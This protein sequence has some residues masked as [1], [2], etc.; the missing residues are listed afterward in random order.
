ME[1]ILASLPAQF[2][3]KL[4]KS[5]RDAYTGQ[6]FLFYLGYLKSYNH[7][8]GYGFLQ[9]DEA[10]KDWGLDVFIHKSQLPQPWA[11]G[12]V[13]EFAVTPNDRGQPQAVDVKWLPVLPRHRQPKAAFQA[14]E[15]AKHELGIDTAEELPPPSVA[16][17]PNVEAAAPDV[18]ANDDDSKLAGKPTQQAAKMNQRKEPDD[19][20]PGAVTATGGRRYL[21]TLKSFSAAQ[22]YGFLA[23]AELWPKYGRDIYF[24]KHQLPSS[25]RLGQSVE[26]AVMLHSSGHPQARWVDWDP[27]P[28]LSPPNSQDMVP[29]EH[30]QQ[31]LKKLTKLLVLVDTGNVESAVIMAMDLH[32]LPGTSSISSKNTRVD[33]VSFV[34]DRIAGPEVV[35]TVLQDFVKM[36]L[37]L[38]LL[39]LIRRRGGGWHSR[40]LVDWF[41]VFAQSIDAEQVAP[42][43]KGMMLEVNN[44]TTSPAIVSLA[45]EAPEAF[46][47]FCSAV[48]TLRAKCEKLASS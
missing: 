28:L 27:V 46:S 16:D 24:G 5:F 30:E 36:L 31:V 8:K 2:H 43:F 32:S 26:F 38:M 45:N 29:L 37:L 21:G 33:Y 12:Q 39:K 19:V 41:R 13:V 47:S 25:W 1:Q 6:K 42:H 17:E 35:V 4:R 48:L 22:G 20:A 14:A 10:N 11:L 40:R 15:V 18:A 9:C 7:R 3:I 34:L 23:C 44:N